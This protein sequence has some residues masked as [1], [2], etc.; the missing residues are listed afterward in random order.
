MIKDKLCLPLETHDQTNAQF[1]PCISSNSY[2]TAFSTFE[3]LCPNFILNTPLENDIKD[4]EYWDNT[5]SC[6]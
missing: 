2:R 6:K 4:K 1:V 5:D 3:L